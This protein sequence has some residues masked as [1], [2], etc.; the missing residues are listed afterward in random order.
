MIPRPY[1]TQK[2][3]KN[4]EFEFLCANCQDLHKKNS[5]QTWSFCNVAVLNSMDLSSWKDG[6][7]VL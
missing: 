7:A 2:Y 4:D 6:F 1:L 5:G 3:R